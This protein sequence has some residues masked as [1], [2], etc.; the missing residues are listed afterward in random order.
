MK[1]LK[2]VKLKD[3]SNTIQITVQEALQ[4]AANSD[5]N[6][7]Q[8]FIMLIKDEKIEFFRGGGLSSS[9]IVWYLE[10]HKLAI[11]ADRLDIYE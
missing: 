4:M 9:D 6:A 7:D 2:L 8:C 1:N 10:K 11:L 3:R 5:F